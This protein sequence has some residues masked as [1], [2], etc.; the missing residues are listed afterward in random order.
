MA[1]A[2]GAQQ[3]PKA[4]LELFPGEPFSPSDDRA[5]L[6]QQLV[7]FLSTDSG[8]EFVKRVKPNGDGRFSIPINFGALVQQCESALAEALDSQPALALDCVS[9]A[10]YEVCSQQQ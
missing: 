2:V 10:A 4:W 9:V 8:W 5:V 1:A 7:A 6:I 3:A